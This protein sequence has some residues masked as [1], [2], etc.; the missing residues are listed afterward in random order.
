MS[1]WCIARSPLMVGGDLPTSSAETVGLLTNDAVLGL[2]RHSHGN[3]E[4][5]RDYGLVVW[6]AEPAYAGLFNLEDQSRTVRLPLA[7]ARLSGATEVNDLWTGD[8]LRVEDGALI[9][10][11]PAHGCVLV[12][13]KT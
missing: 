9:T 2:L 6:A 10:D 12:R 5:I 11:L 4:V 3:R 1:L 7:D 8:P 13:A